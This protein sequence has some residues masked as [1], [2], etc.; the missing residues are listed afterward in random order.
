ML[1][2]IFHIKPYTETV[3][4]ADGETVQVLYRDLVKLIAPDLGAEYTQQYFEVGDRIGYWHYANPLHL[5]VQRYMKTAFSFQVISLDFSPKSFIEAFAK[6]RQF[7][8]DGKPED[9]DSYA[10]IM[11]VIAD[12]SD[13]DN[14]WLNLATIFLMDESEN[15]FQWNQKAAERKLIAMKTLPKVQRDKIITFAQNYT[16]SFLSM[17]AATA[18]EFFSE[19]KEG[20]TLPFHATIDEVMTKSRDM[21]ILIQQMADRNP[22]AA[23]M[24]QQFTAESF[25]HDV[26][27]FVQMNKPPEND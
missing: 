2:N 4:L 27:I 10:A 24:L 21:N 6:I 7:I 11:Q 26:S 8:K 23:D 22:L 9:A 25:F 19:S 5:P 18:P 15:P 1:N 13:H 12:A 16:S 14:K 3:E 20:E 17:M